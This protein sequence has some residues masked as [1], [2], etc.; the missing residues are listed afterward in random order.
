[1]VPTDT[2]QFSYLIRHGPAI[3]SAYTLQ[4]KFCIVIVAHNQHLI[5]MWEQRKGGAEGK[6]GKGGREERRKRKKEGRENLA[7]KLS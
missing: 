4:E 6:E 2:F 5:N 7:L 3:L 1:M